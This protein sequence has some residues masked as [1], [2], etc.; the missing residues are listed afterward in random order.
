MCFDEFDELGYQS[1]LVQPV[2][3]NAGPSSSVTSHLVRSSKARCLAPLSLSLFLLLSSSREGR[4]IVSSPTDIASHGIASPSPMHPVAFAYFQ[5]L[6]IAS[7]HPL[8]LQ[9][10]AMLD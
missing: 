3:P 5:P 4:T 7:V 1:E 2:T 8:S 6:A 9:V 10:S